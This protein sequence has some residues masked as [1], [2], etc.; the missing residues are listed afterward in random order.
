M[1]AFYI[2]IVS[3][4]NPYLLYFT[5]HSIYEALCA[6]FYPGQAEVQYL[7]QCESVAVALTQPLASLAS[8]PE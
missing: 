7:S 3:R 8:L 6:W 1:I 5:Y 4:R 2:M